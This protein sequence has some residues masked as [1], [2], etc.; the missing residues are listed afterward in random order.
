MKYKRIEKPVSAVKWDGR[1]S[2]IENIGFLKMTDCDFKCGILYYDEDTNSLYF[3]DENGKLNEILINDFIIIKDDN[4]VYSVSEK[5][6]NNCFDLVGEDW[7]EKLIG[8]Y[9]RFVDI[10]AELNQAY[11]INKDKEIGKMIK[12]SI[13]NIVKYMKSVELIIMKISET[14]K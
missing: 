10:K 11:E 13:D 7:K 8:H 12:S 1:K 9:N 2:T 5:E 14:N 4:S 3:G 6:F